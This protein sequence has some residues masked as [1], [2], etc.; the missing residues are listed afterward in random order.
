MFIL[1]Q[2]VLTIVMMC[3]HVLGMSEQSDPVRCSRSRLLGYR[4]VGPMNS[5]ACCS[6][7][8][9]PRGCY[10]HALA[11]RSLP[12]ARRRNHVVTR[13]Q[14]LTI[15]KVSVPFKTTA[16]VS[17]KKLAPR[18]PP[19]TT[20]LVVPAVTR[21][22]SNNRRGSNHFKRVHSFS[23]LSLSPS[24]KLVYHLQSHLRVNTIWAFTIF[25]HEMFR[26]KKHEKCFFVQHYL[27]RRCVWSLH[28][29]GF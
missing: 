15:G 5:T 12:E 29:H 21:G 7:C 19:H 4:A 6:P 8:S 13:L 27:L 11:T 16:L 26:I 22:Y 23:H 14:P 24:I 17:G 25:F 1:V 28:A 3:C 9:P 2:S 18:L 10:M 20:V